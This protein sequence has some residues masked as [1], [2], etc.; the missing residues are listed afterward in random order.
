MSYSDV[1]EVGWVYLPPKSAGKAGIG[2]VSP[3]K[4]GESRFGTML[5]YNSPQKVQTKLGESAQ[6]R[7][8]IMPADSADEVRAVAEKLDELGVWE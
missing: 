7:F 5:L 8:A 2:W 6:T 3:L 4:F 1:G